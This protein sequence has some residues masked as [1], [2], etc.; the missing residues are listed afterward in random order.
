MFSQSLPQ[1]GKEGQQYGG[2]SQL[3][4]ALDF[5]ISGRGTGI[6]AGV[7]AGSTRMERASGKLPFPWPDLTHIVMDA[8]LQYR[9]FFQLRNAKLLSTLQKWKLY[10]TLQSEL[11]VKSEACYS[12]MVVYRTR[13][14][15]AY[16]RGAFKMVDR[17]LSLLRGGVM[18]IVHTKLSEA[19]T[20]WREVADEQARLQRI[21]ARSMFMLFG[22]RGWNT[23][24]EMAAARKHYLVLHF[25]AMRRLGK[26]VYKGVIEGWRHLIEEEALQRRSGGLAW[27]HSI[28]KKKLKTIRRLRSFGS[29]SGQHIASIEMA[30][31]LQV[32]LRLRWWRH[33]ARILL[34]DSNDQREREDRQL[35]RSD[36]MERWKRAEEDTLSAQM[37][38]EILESRTA[39]LAR[40]VELDR[41]HLGFQV[42]RRV[43][44][45]RS[46]MQAA[47]MAWHR[48]Q[49]SEVLGTAKMAVIMLQDELSLAHNGWTAALLGE[50]LRSAECDALRN[51]LRTHLTQIDAAFEIQRDS[52]DCLRAYEQEAKLRVEA[53][54]ELEEAALDLRQ[55]QRSFLFKA[56]RH[57][58]H[59]CTVTSCWSAL[60]A[61][62]MQMQGNSEQAHTAY[63]QRVANEMLERERAG[64]ETKVRA[65][66]AD[67]ITA[68]EVEN[69]ALVTEKAM[70]EQQARTLVAEDIQDL[71]RDNMELQ[72]ACIAMAYQ[73]GLEVIRAR[74]QTW[75][76]SVTSNLLRRWQ[77]NQRE[78][79]RHVEHSMALAEI[80]KAKHSTED[81]NAQLQKVTMQLGQLSAY[82]TISQT[83]RRWCTSA[84]VRAVTNWR[85]IM[86]WDKMQYQLD[87]QQMTLRSTNVCSGLLALLRTNMNWGLL[88]ASRAIGKWKTSMRDATQLDRLRVSEAALEKI[89]SH[90]KDEAD[91]RIAQFDAENKI[92]KQE[93]ARLMVDYDRYTAKLEMAQTTSNAEMRVV[94]A[95]LRVRFEEEEAK[96]HLEA[97]RL[98][99][100]ITSMGIVSGLGNLGTTLWL[101]RLTAV[102]SCIRRWLLR[103]RRGV[104]DEGV[105]ELNEAHQATMLKK[106]SDCVDVTQHAVN[107]SEENQRLKDGLA[108]LGWWCAFELIMKG[109]PLVMV[110]LLLHT[111]YAQWQHFK[112][113]HHHDKELVAV[114]ERYKKQLEKVMQ[115][116][117]QA[118]EIYAAR[119]HMLKDSI[120]AMG[121]TG[122][123]DA[124][125]RMFYKWKWDVCGRCFRWWWVR[126]AVDS[127]Q[128]VA[129]GIEDQLAA[130]VGHLQATMR[131]MSQHSGFD[132]LRRLLDTRKRAQ[133]LRHWYGNARAGCI[134]DALSIQIE[135]WHDERIE[136]LGRVTSLTKALRGMGYSSALEMWSHFFMKS[137]GQIVLSVVRRWFMRSVLNKV[138]DVWS[139]HAEIEQT[140][141]C[142]F[143]DLSLCQCIHALL[144]YSHFFCFVGSQ[145]G[146]FAMRTLEIDAS[147]LETELGD[148]HLSM[149]SLRAASKLQMS[150][151]GMMLAG[152]AWGA[153]RS[154]DMLRIMNKIHCNYQEHLYQSLQIRFSEYADSADRH[155]KEMREAYED[156]LTAALNTAEAESVEQST[157]LAVTRSALEQSERE[158]A[159]MFNAV[160]DVSKNSGLMQAGATL[161]RL[162]HTHML[163][164]VMWWYSHAASSRAVAQ[165]IAI[166]IEEKKSFL[167]RAS[168][169]QAAAL[170]EQQRLLEQ[171]HSTVVER[172]RLQMQNE[173][174]EL[175]KKMETAAGN[176]EVLQTIV[177][178]MAHGGALEA[179]RHILRNW[180]E[181]QL[182]RAVQTWSLNVY[183][184]G[185][186]SL[187]KAASMAQQMRDVQAQ[188]NSK[189]HFSC[190]TV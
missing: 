74:M 181:L 75:L 158:K 112:R 68:L 45:S 92:L 43:F 93:N 182:N 37:K 97:Q 98:R 41:Y 21:L 16:W 172:V 76:F 79:R 23:W 47:V 99:S 64:M 152:T 15:L 19:V 102:T 143:A 10:Y 59:H 146:S 147:R 69:T 114:S 138:E 44:G 26:H 32:T 185:H 22:K 25:S 90:V 85:S 104:Y 132:I 3:H 28:R 159:M 81:Y 169:D 127:T 162:R 78:Y 83:M 136:L 163:S 145:E 91:A 1:V 103:T 11:Q 2:I 184:N 58:V 50:G 122:A 33:V 86:V 149:Q 108:H 173:S 105:N 109:R 38:V 34:A 73:S 60:C 130:R 183:H 135:V 119:E 36:M 166:T 151:A 80:E 164:A 110:R 167:S 139:A 96:L 148:A 88:R 30:V 161:L 128:Y 56:M 13:R 187:V 168:A 20:W 8:V 24:R 121:Y 4:C 100:I 18:R 52:E 177:R 49:Q 115:G 140:V 174:L 31:K 66:I 125:S 54:N 71:K 113:A 95:E 35:R 153:Q 118:S 117:L 51:E 40:G 6:V 94:E 46:V 154:V 180:S 186:S 189:V 155:R 65:T 179:L 63:V 134:S 111:W 17:R 156:K 61:W 72:E 53:E 39:E 42:S 101:W 120:R 124:W 116:E 62:K 55:T 77:Q 176:G 142:V 87:L 84:L 141:R 67:Q 171:H 12:A 7:E 106:H 190:F 150:R 107:L 144:L 27:L 178:D 89:E 137:R 14:S 129:R 82:E 131:G 165:Q 160:S 48:Q 29:R 133:L 175:Q 157:G 57:W 170:E 5:E 188:W 126:K 9:V 123:F 70:F